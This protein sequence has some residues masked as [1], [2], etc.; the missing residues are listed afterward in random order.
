VTT[1]Q[2]VRC[3]YITYNDGFA[4]QKA[5]PLLSAADVFARYIAGARKMYSID[6]I[7]HTEVL[8]ATV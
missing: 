8:Y 7:P 1:A 2:L 6:I 5:L 3:M 4:A